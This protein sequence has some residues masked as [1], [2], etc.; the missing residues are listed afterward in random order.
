[1]FAVL[2]LM[3]L[4]VIFYNLLVLF[5]AGGLRSGAAAE[6]MR[7]T[8]MSLPLPSGGGWTITLGDLIVA[9]S[10]A[11]FFIELL[12]AEGGRPVAIVAHTLAMV[13][14]GICLV[15]FLLFK[16]FPTTAFFFITVMVLLDLAA[17]FISTLMAERRGR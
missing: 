17:G 4:P 15:E 11:I 14:F 13:L 3:A 10:L 7:E 5:T 8:M 1:M 16:S 9:L 2:P 12:K 6:R